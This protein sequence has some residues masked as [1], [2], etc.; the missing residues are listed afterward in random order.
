RHHEALVR[1]AAEYGLTDVVRFVRCLPT[2][3]EM[4]DAFDAADLFVLPSRTEGLPR[5]LVEAAARAM[6]AIGSAVG[7][8]VELLAPEDQVEPGDSEQLA[9]RITSLLA[10]PQWLAAAS[11]RNLAT[12][13]SYSLERLREPALAYYRAV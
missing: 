9:E 5:V 8:V 1:R 2:R 12:A 10:D 6:P 4:V 11:A 7:G 13:R 3:R